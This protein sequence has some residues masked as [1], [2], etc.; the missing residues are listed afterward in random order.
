[1][2]TAYYE[3]GICRHHA[4]FGMYELGQH[5]YSTSAAWADLMDLEQAMR[6]GARGELLPIDEALADADFLA[7]GIEDIRGKIYGGNPDYIYAILSDDGEIAYTGVTSVDKEDTMLSLQAVTPDGKLVA[8]APD[9]DVLV[10]GNNGSADFLVSWATLRADDAII[11]EN[12]WR[13]MEGVSPTTDLFLV[14]A[15]DAEKYDEENNVVER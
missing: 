7:A 9:D 2:S 10:Y 11:R 6:D 14:R 13:T 15:E 5:H 3:I 8:I 1:M 12:Y 4:G